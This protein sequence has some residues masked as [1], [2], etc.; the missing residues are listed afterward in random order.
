MD[1]FWKYGDGYVASDGAVFHAAYLYNVASANIGIVRVKTDGTKK[2]YA[3]KLYANP[4]LAEKKACEM[5]D[6]Y[7]ACLL[8][9]EGEAVLA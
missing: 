1:R 4:E 7:N 5:R 8:L 3:D 6:R 9:H 2:I